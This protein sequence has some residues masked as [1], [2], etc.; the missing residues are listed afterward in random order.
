M[1]LAQGEA[2]LWGSH[3][4]SRLLLWMTC[5]SY[6][7]KFQPNRTNFDWISRDPAVVDAYATDPEC[8]FPFT[9][10]AYYNMFRGMSKIVR[11]V[12]L[13][14]MPK[15]LPVLFA[16]GGRDP[17]GDFGRGV[18]KTEEIFRQAGMRHV[19]C[20]LYPEDRHEILNEPD[21]RQVYEDIWEW[22]RQQVL[23]ERN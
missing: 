2:K 17:V 14:Q 12:D 19:K 9:V 13:A 4:R 1:M 10:N 23:K 15:E 22:M 11:P 8:G 6:N 18:R 21:R 5:G 20:I 3:Y 16:A 7:A